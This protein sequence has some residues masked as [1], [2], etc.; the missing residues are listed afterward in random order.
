MKV[1]NSRGGTETRE[2]PPRMPLKSPELQLRVLWEAARQFEEA[3]D[4]AINQY[5]TVAGRSI[6]PSSQAT[7]ASELVE[8]LIC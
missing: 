8:P 5:R 6:P 7:P 2:P 3:V 1:R 4:S